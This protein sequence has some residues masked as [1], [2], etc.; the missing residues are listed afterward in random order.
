M[1]LNLAEMTGEQLESTLSE[2]T[3]VEAVEG[4]DTSTQPEAEPSE[5]AVPAVETV[6]EPTTEEAAQPITVEALQAQLKELQENLKNK[7]V[8]M[9]KWSNEIGTIRKQFQQNP[10]VKVDMPTNEEF[11][12][13]PAAATEKLLQAKEAVKLQ[14][15]AAYER[16]SSEVMA[17]NKAIT[18]HFV[19][20][21]DDL[22]PDIIETLRNEDG[23]DDRLLAEFN[24]TPYAT[25]HTT[26]VQLGKRV[27]IKKKLTAAESRIAE[28]E[29]K[30]KELKGK[31]D[32]MLDR[33]DKASR[34]AP[35]PVKG[36]TTKDGGSE[37]GF[38][39]QQLTSMSKADL[40]RIL[41]ESD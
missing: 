28:L 23:F 18:N 8:L 13:D 29:A 15:Q 9:G 5:G 21:F 24:K 10:E 11:F 39:I 33:I 1:E 36:S 22:L 6:A 7:D 14:A 3:G 37:S 4:V 26:L 2:D 35:T 12:N 16:Q 25:N 20:N 19:E 34:N 31:P 17:Q 27:Q 41:K 40:E 38:S 30:V 32:E